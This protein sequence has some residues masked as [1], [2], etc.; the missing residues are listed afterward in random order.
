M[1]KILLTFIFVVAV[2]VAAVY[3][4]GAMALA[5]VLENAIG[6]PVSVGR[7]HLGLLS[8]EIG[9]YGLKIK[10]PEGK[11][12][13]EKTMADVNEIS[14]KYV[15]ADI[16]QG[17]IHITSMTLNFGDV[18]VEKGK[19]GVNLLEIG[20]IKGI[21]SGIGSGKKEE[22][23]GKTEPEKGK[24]SPA[25]KGPVLQ[26]DEVLV[27]MGKARYVDSGAEPSVVKELDLAVHNEKI[28]DVTSGPA[29]VKDLVF[30]ILRKVGVSSLANFD[31]LMQGVGGGIGSTWDKMFKK[32]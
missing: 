26:I 23:P 4:F 18:T 11:E 24:P 17:K 25:Q 3:F 1:K 16:F 12:F 31:L 14:F 22:K 15:P 28:K 5:H 27:N 7:L 10:N 13:K 29:L 30:L 2:V 21:T 19:G 32:S 9:L 8:S 6:T 20:A